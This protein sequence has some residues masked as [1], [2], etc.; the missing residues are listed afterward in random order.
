MLQDGKDPW[1]SEAFT[2]RLV[3]LAPA[4]RLIERRSPSFVLEFN[5]AG[6]GN[7]PR[8]FATAADGEVVEHGLGHDSFGRAAILLWS[9]ATSVMSARF[10]CA[11][12][13][14]HFLTFLTLEY[15]DDKD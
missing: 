2:N 13:E 4:A 14:T 10:V 5:L 8:D 11:D 9:S 1:E 7:E 15:L 12:T 6:G 3:A